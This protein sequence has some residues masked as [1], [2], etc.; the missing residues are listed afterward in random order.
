M[1]PQTNSIQKPK[2]LNKHVEQ[3]GNH[4]SKRSTEHF[5]VPAT[6]M[7]I[8]SVS[9]CS[10]R[11][12]VCVMSTIYRFTIVYSLRARIFVHT[13]S[14]I[15]VESPFFGLLRI[16]ERMWPI[17]MI[18]KFSEIF[19]LFFFSLLF[20]SPMCLGFGFPS[21]FKFRFIFHSKL[22]DVFFSRSENSLHAFLLLF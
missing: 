19:F 17:W 4:I 18:L 22:S 6:S 3:I 12:G 16:S 9:A 8:L 2:S 10:I 13:I 7:R 14:F 21:I 11:C 15:R 1:V 5:R 20:A